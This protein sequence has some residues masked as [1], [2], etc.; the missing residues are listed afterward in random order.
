ML[1]LRD[2]DRRVLA[3][4]RAYGHY[5]WRFPAKS[6]LVRDLLEEGVSEA[7]LEKRVGASLARLRKDGYLQVEAVNGRGLTS[8]Q[9]CAD[10]LRRI[11]VLL[12]TQGNEEFR[13]L[14]ESIPLASVYDPAR[15][16]CLRVGSEEF[17]QFANVLS[18]D[19]ILFEEGLPRDGEIT[20]ARHLNKVWVGKFGHQGTVCGIY[21]WRTRWF[22]PVPRTALMGTA[23]AVIRTLPGPSPDGKIV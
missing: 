2:L 17:A 11:P 9:H 8:T 16:F 15:T 20:A 18:G 12:E 14:Q 10:S 19:L 1:G 22:V 7:G 6:E 3:L 21:S 23:R 4:V 13:S 5:Q